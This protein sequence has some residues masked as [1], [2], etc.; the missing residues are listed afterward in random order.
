MG[1]NLKVGLQPPFL[2]SVPALY[3][4]NGLVLDSLLMGMDRAELGGTSPPPGEF[5]ETPGCI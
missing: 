2:L 5:P 1:R 4:T 3:G